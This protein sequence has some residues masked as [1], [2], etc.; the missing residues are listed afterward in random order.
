[1]L[2]YFMV[3]SVGALVGSLIMRI[4]VAFIGYRDGRSDW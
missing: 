1:M 2:S 4:Y 3:F